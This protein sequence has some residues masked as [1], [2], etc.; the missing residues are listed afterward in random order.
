MARAFLR[1]SEGLVALLDDGERTIL[2]GLMQQTLSLI[3]I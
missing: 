2:S 1:E 3:H